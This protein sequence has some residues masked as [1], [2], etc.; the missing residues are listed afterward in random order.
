MTGIARRH[1]GAWR[2]LLL[3]ATSIVALPAIAGGQTIGTFRWQTAPFCN[4]VTLTVTPAGSAFRLEGS[5]DQCGDAVAAPVMGTAIANPNGSIGLGVVIIAAPDGTPL[6]LDASIDLATLGGEWRDS[7]GR[8]GAF[9]FTP[10]AGNGG[11]RRP[12]VP[13]ALGGITLGFGLTTVDEGRVLQLDLQQVQAGLQY[14]LFDS[15]VAI[16]AEAMRGATPQ[17]ASNVA[18]GPRAL[19]DVTDGINN[20]AIGSN[21]LPRLTSGD[22]NVA[23]GTDALFSLR[24]GN[25][26]IG[27]GGAALA[28]NTAGERNVAIGASA[29]ASATGNDNIA[30][31]V[32]AGALLVGGSHNVYIANN[33]LAADD[34]IIRI[35]TVGTHV[36]AVIAGIAGQTSVGGVAVFVNNVGKLGTMGSSA[37]FK[38]DIQPIAGVRDKLHALRPVQFVYKPEFDDGSRQLQYGLIA[39]EVAEVFPELVVRDEQGEPLTVRYHLLAPLL[40]DEMQ[41]LHAEIEALKIRA[42][43]KRAP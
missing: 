3:L 35:G 40:L 22:A 42:A 13:L 2:P 20:V 30:I 12:D 14:R 11:A 27:I 32:N 16:G 9:I 38:D 5:D 37:R 29:L 24:T 31:G 39:E 8:R 25:L 19:H 23:V 4:V 10:G 26:N 33:G 41:R 17:A 15:N 34:R 6:H 43:T 7:V 36:G 18:I 1:R 28:S 21:A